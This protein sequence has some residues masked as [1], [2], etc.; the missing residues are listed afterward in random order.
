M[1]KKKNATKKKTNAK[2]KKAGKIVDI[3]NIDSDKNVDM[4]K[5]ERKPKRKKGKILFAA[6]V[7]LFILAAASVA[8]FFVFNKDFSS[9][10]REVKVELNIN[11]VEEMASGEQIEIEITYENKEDV[12]I[13]EG[14]ITIHYP[15]GFYFQKAEPQANTSDNSWNI[16]NVEAGAGGK[17]TITGQLVGE[18]DE[19]KEFTGFLT[20][21]P[22]NFNSNFQDT[23]NKLV[24]INDTIVDLET[25]LPELAFSGQE[26]EYEVKFVNTSSLPLPNV[27]V[28]IAYPSDFTLASADPSADL[29]S[30]VWKY[31]E[32]NPDEEIIIK[33]KGAIK[34]KS[35]ENKEF[36]FQL[37]LE[38]PNGFVNKQVEKS[39]LILIVNPDINLTLEAPENVVPGEEVEYKIK[40]EN[41]SDIAISDIELKLEF[42]EGLTEKKSVTLDKI[43]N[44]KAGQA[45]ESTKK[46]VV[47]KKIKQGLSELKAKL[48]VKTGK[49]EGREFTFEQTAEAISKIK[50]E[51][52]FSAQAR[53]YDDDLTK[54]GNGPVPPKVGETTMY[55]VWWEVKAKGGDLKDIDITT[56]LPDSADK[57]EGIT[58]GVEY[59]K[60]KKQIKWKIDE[61]AKGETTQGVF[62]VYVTPVQSQVNKLLVLTKEAVANA[63]DVNTK[64]NIS[65]NI[66]KITSDLPNDPVASGQGVVEK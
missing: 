46:I 63:V 1:P 55:Q 20:Y 18:L 39:N 44:L 60:D 64:E 4:T 31:T 59:N 56:T 27:K 11:T 2:S 62:T 35:N 5:L 16:A 41:I 26:V 25:S 24:K 43:D 61:L 17:I 48:S 23:A 6:I 9:E 47:K 58:R 14:E 3:Y 45:D 28:E 42:T 40:I 22:I 15:N 33:I 30:N 12:A 66:E 19:E 38:E 53:Y 7:L 36:K 34:G 49:V 8:G 32:L 65:L 52:Q 50:A 54:L 21:K 13:K 10:K 29:G 51:M 57:A 37:G